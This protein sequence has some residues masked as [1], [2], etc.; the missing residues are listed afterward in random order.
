VYTLSEFKKHLEILKD[1]QFLNFSKPDSDQLSSLVFCENIN[2]IRTAISNSNV[3]AIITTEKLLK[4]IEIEFPFIK[5]GLAIAGSPKDVYWWI[6]SCAQLDGRLHPTMDYGVD[7]ASNIHP[8]AFISKK[9]KVGRNVTIGANVVIGDYSFIS[10]G[11]EIHEGCI[12]G[13]EGMQLFNGPD[14]RIS[15][16]RHAGGVKLGQSAVLLSRAI[17]SKAVH[18]LFTEIGNETCLSLMVSVGHQSIVGSKC[19]IAGNSILGGSVI[20]GDR[21]IVGPSVTIKDGLKIGNG[22]YI[23]IGSVVINDV[24]DGGDVSGNFAYQHSKNLRSF[25]RMRK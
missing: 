9:V 1:C 23:R 24:M 19:R 7:E 10:D 11:V 13:A 25:S 8:T 14:G 4:F 5:K 17:V 16:V 2:A 3:C 21:V 22:A 18:P 15:I 20:M 12:V 6:F